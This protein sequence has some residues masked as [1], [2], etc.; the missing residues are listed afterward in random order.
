MNKL[1]LLNGIRLLTQTIRDLCYD[2]CDVHENV[3]EKKISYP[4]KLFHDYPNSPCLVNKRREFVLELKR[5][6]PARVQTEMLE[7]IAL[8]FEFSSKLKILSFHVV[9]VQGRQ[10]NVQKSVMHVQNCCFAH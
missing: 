5:G 10:R 8:L 7:F 6:G 3:A 1:Q 2:V 9:V 4:F